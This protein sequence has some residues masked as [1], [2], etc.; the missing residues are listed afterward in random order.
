[1]R[2]ALKPGTVNI[3]Q[4]KRRVRDKL[5]RAGVSILGVLLNGR[6]VDADHFDYKYLNYG[7]RPPSVEGPAS[8]EPGAGDEREVP[9]GQSAGSGA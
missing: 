6:K 4:L 5:L 9:I 3:E 2:V 8:K 1:M 7:D